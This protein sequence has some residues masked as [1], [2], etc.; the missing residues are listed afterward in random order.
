MCP[1]QVLDNEVLVA[2][3]FD[4]FVVP[5]FT[6]RPKMRTEQNYA[7]LPDALLYQLLVKAP[8]AGL[9]TLESHRDRWIGY[10]QSCSDERWAQVVLPL[11][12]S[13]LEARYL[14]V[15]KAAA[16]QGG[17]ELLFR[18]VQAGPLPLPDLVHLRTV[19][20]PALPVLP[21]LPVLLVYALSRPAGL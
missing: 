20:E 13:S 7:R 12:G 17:K 6:K 9:L 18:A 2:E 8:L 19:S 3:I 16:S 1:V 15:Y 14:D 10:V 4:S 11:L 21:V 5:F